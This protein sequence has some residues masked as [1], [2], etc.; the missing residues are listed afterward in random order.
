MYKG[1]CAAWEG[2]GMMVGRCKKEEG[3]ISICI[4]PYNTKD[5]FNSIFTPF[6]SKALLASELSL[7][8]GRSI[9]SIPMITHPLRDGELGGGGGA[10][11]VRCC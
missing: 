6:G 8:F 1:S 10:G 5:I 2:R 7:A 4:N 11:G 3:N 9:H